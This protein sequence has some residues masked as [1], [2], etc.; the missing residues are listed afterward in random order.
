MFGCSSHIK[1]TT[2]K[3]QTPKFFKYFQLS[4]QT[5]ELDLLAEHLSAIEYDNHAVCG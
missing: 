5:A 4:N 2:E 1:K 3:V